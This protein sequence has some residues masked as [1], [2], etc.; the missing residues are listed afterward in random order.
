M[1]KLLTIVLG[2]AA[3][4]ACS[5]K[6]NHVQSPPGYDFSKPVIYKM[7]DELDEISGIAFYP[8]KSDIMYAIQD[9]EGKLFRWQNGRP[10]TMEH[11]RF[12]KRGDYEDVGLLRDRTV[13]LRSDGSLFTFP[14]G[15]DTIDEAAVQEWKGLLPE[16]EYEGLYA[17]ADR[18]EIYVLCKSCAADKKEASLSGYILQVDGRGAPV[19]KSGFSI[20][21]GSSL[22]PGKEAQKR[23][24]ASALTF[25]K[26]TG[27]WYVLSS[28]HKLLIIADS[29]WNIK[30]VIPLQP[31]LFPQPEGITFDI[32]NNL[33]ISN[34]AGGTA[35]G[36]VLKFI[37]N[38]PQR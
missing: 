33:Y 29:G 7:P 21:T 38:K 13:V 31:S 26:Q 10:E 2:L 17:D 22:L 3:F 28:V 19:V 25:D 20:A 16:G 32:D 8:G 24:R 37:F 34:E 5:N 6:G 35:A 36:T 11:S 14:A 1:N 18:N 27:S 15:T 23:L 4:P 30:Q 12:G 9:E